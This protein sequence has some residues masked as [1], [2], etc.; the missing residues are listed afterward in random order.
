MDFLFFIDFFGLNIGFLSYKYKR[1]AKRI[2]VHKNVRNIKKFMLNGA[3]MTLCS[4]LMRTVAVSFNVY[5]ANTAGAEAVGLY[6]LLSSVYGFAITLALSGLHLAVTR[7]VSEALALGDKNK[8]S[9]VMKKSFFYAASFG[10]LSMILLLSNTLS[11]NWLGDIR[12]VKPFKILSI[13]LPLISISSVI[14]GYFAAVRR[15]FKSAISQ[16]FEMLIKIICSS[17]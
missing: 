11:V 14:N 13:C 5:V 4:L 16:L 7:L 15:V 3:M 12:T 2:E 9:Q 6:S 17:I 1:T 8:V 10:L